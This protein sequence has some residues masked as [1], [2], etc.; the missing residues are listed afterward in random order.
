MWNDANRKVALAVVERPPGM[1][2]HVAFLQPL[3]ATK[4]RTVFVSGC[5]LLVKLGCIMCVVG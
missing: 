3:I 2:I 4:N 1:V 5:F